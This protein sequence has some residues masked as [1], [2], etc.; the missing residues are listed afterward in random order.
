MG[1]IARRKHSGAVEW[2]LKE[3][4]SAQPRDDAAVRYEG[5]VRTPRGQ[6]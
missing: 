5:L 3:I 1:E 4:I 6:S 2:T